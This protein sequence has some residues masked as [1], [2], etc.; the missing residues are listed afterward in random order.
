VFSPVT[1][2]TAELVVLLTVRV[3]DPITTHCGSWNFLARG[4]RG[5][6]GKSKDV[7]EGPCPEEYIGAAEKAFAKCPKFKGLR[8][9]SAEARHGFLTVRFEGPLDDHRGP[10]D[11][12]VHLPDNARH[13]QNGPGTQQ[14]G[15]G[16]ESGAGGVER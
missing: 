1:S 9:L 13:A 8:Y 16:A 14:P 15:T 2:T 5:V 3:V 12:I 10:Y 4:E 6:T 7:M 11:V